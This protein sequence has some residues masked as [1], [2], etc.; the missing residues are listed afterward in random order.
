MEYTNLTFSKFKKKKEI[1]NYYL[2]SLKFVKIK[3]IIKKIIK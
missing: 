1:V 3:I 2:K